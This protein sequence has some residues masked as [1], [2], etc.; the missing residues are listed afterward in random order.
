VNERIDSTT[1]AATKMSIWKIACHLYRINLV[2]NELMSMKPRLANKK[3]PHTVG[4]TLL[5]LL[6]ENLLM[7]PLIAPLT[8]L[9]PRPKNKLNSGPAIHP[10]IAIL[11]NPF[12]DTARFAIISP[13]ELPHASTVTPRKA[14][15]ILKITPKRDKRSIRTLATHQIHTRD[16]TNEHKAYKI[17]NLLGACCCFVV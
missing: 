5:L 17:I 3:A 1:I 11:A 4:S 15:L 16:I 8:K 14:A 12:F 7:F 10:V 6:N 9:I 2:K 13:T